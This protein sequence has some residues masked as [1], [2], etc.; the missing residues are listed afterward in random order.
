VLED[1]VFLWSVTI[2]VVCPSWKETSH[3]SHKDQK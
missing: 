2:A 1:A 3:P